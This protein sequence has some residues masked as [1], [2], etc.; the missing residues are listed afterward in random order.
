MKTKIYSITALILSSVL[1]ISFVRDDEAIKKLILSFQ[2]FNNSHVQEKVYLHTDKPYYA[3]GDEI[4]FKAYVVDAQ[5]MGPT[6][7]S[8]YLYVDLINS[9]DS[10]KKTLKLPLVAGLG[11][12]NFELKDSLKEGNYRLRAYTQWMRNFGEAYFYDKIIKVGDA[13]TNQLIT[14]ASYTFEK[15]GNTEAVSA[16]VNFSNIDGKP[17]ANKE[18]T[19]NVELDFRAITKGKGITDSD[20][21]LTIKFV[22]DKP[23]LAKSGR[24]TTSLKIAENTSVTK[25]IP[26]KNTSNETA[27]QFFPEGGDLIAGI[28]GKVAFK[29]LNAEG[30]GE[31]VEGYIEDNEGTRVFNFK[32]QHL[33]MGITSFTPSEG[34]TY[35]AVVNFKDGSEKK[36][37]LAIVKAEGLSLN[38]NQ[39]LKDSLTVKISSNRA[40]A[41]KNADKIYTIIAQSS[42]N[43]VYTAKSKLVGL[44]FA[45]KLS[46]SRFPDGITQ[47]TLFDENMQPL[48]ERLI[49]TMPR[50]ILKLEVNPDKEEYLQRGKT[51]LNI[52]ATDPDG[53]PVFGSYS[54]SVT[55]E[56]KVLLNEDEESTIFNSLLFTSD[57]KGYIEKPNYYFNKPNEQKLADMDILMMTQG[58]RRFTWK[59][60]YYETF[61]ALSYNPEKT[62]FVKG[63]L[64]S[65]KDKPVVDGTV[66]LLSSGS[67]SLLV[68]AKTDAKG[69]FLIDSLFYPDSTRF[70]VQGRNAKGGK[71]V[72]I[73]LFTYPLQIVTKNTNTAD[74]TTNINQSML[75]YLKNSKTQYEEWLKNGIVNRSILLNEV[76]VVDTKPKVENSTNLNGAGNADRVLNEK[77]FEFAITMEQAL[78]GRVAGLQITG[79]IAYIRGAQAQIIIDGIFVEPDFLNSINIRDV[80]SIEI[81]KSVGYTAIYG[82]RGAGGVIVINTKRGK[83]NY[84]VNNYAPGIITYYPIG[85]FIPKEFY[86][87]NYDDPKLNEQVADLRTTI[88]WKPNVLTDSTGTGD[89]EFFNADGVGNYKVVLEG[90]DLNGHLGRKVIRYQVK[91]KN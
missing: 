18:V 62:T 26:I 79:G 20:G 8:N 84:T 85:L 35:Q 40:F 34:K 15:T 2:K 29:A 83:A 32:S 80:E 72:E 66:S 57:L 16:A 52:K 31:D 23:F 69:E 86:V 24:I 89:V 64:T 17:Y 87:P 44:N 54:V 65:G 39:N 74:L 70:V 68:Q 61:P 60:I 42:G 13:W 12:G 48:A 47:F 3:I 6:S 71:N 67:T 10:I 14:N 27:I 75:A 78:Q 19:Y 56:T 73:E 59:N 33:G 88:F 21:N 9:R 90:M 77:D 1:L 11:W 41:D 38:V 53:N 55:D 36:V 45:A 49:F 25:Y 76:K 7:Q 58:W 82:V 4:W 63:R 22:N 30:L 50:N 46:K 5:N 28:R 37:K 91:P 81:L 43:I 51:K